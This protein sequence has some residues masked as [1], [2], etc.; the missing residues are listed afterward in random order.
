M[1]D[2]TDSTIHQIEFELERP[3]TAWR[4]PM[5]PSACAI[6][7]VPDLVPQPTPF[8]RCARRLG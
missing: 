4:C 6:C 2:D 7:T 8:T 1:S 3:N 5:T